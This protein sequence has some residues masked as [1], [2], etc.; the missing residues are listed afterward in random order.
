VSASGVYILENTPGG[1][2]E[3]GEKKKVAN[4]KEKGRNGKKNKENGK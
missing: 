4:V 3:K 1:K 2:Y